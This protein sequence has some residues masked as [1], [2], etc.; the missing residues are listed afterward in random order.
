MAALPVIVLSGIFVHVIKEKKIIFIDDSLSF[1][2]W[3][4]VAIS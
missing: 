1:G 3:G 2:E 4:V